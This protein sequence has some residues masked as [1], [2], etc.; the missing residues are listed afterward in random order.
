MSLDSDID[1]KSSTPSLYSQSWSVPKVFEEEAGNDRSTS[2]TNGDCDFSCAPDLINERYLYFYCSHGKIPSKTFVSLDLETYKARFIELDVDLEWSKYS[3]SLV[4]YKNNLV[5]FGKRKTD[6]EERNHQNDFLLNIVGG[7][8]QNCDI[9]KIDDFSFSS[10]HGYS[11]DTLDTNIFLFGGIVNEEYS[12]DILVM[13]L[14]G[15]PISPKSY[16]TDKENA[17]RWS[18]LPL[19]SSSPPGRCNHATTMIGNKLIVHG[20]K[21]KTGLL[22]DLWLLDLDTMSWTEIRPVGGFPCPREGHKFVPLGNKFYMYG[23]FDENQVIRN[24]LWCFNLDKQCWLRTKGPSIAEGNARFLTMNSCNDR[25]F[26]TFF[27]KML[28]S[29]HFHCYECDPTRLSWNNMDAYGLPVFNHV[30][31]NSSNTFNYTIPLGKINTS[32][33]KNRS[34]ASFNFYDYMEPSHKTVK[35]LGHRHYGS[36][37]EQGLEYLKGKK[38]NSLHHRRNSDNLSLREFGQSSPFAYDVDKTITSLPIAYDEEEDNMDNQ[39]FLSVPDYVSNRS[40]DLQTFNFSSTDDRI[41]WLEEQLLFCMT[42]G[43][44]LKP[45]GHLREKYSKGIHIHSQPLKMLESLHVMEEELSKTEFEFNR[46]ACNMISEN[47]QLLAEKDAAQSSVEFHIKLLQESNINSLTRMLSERVHTL[48]IDVQHSLA[49]ATFY[50]QGY[51]EL[52]QKV[53]ELQCMNSIMRNHQAELN[54]NYEKL[55]SVFE[56][57]DIRVGLLQTENNLLKLDVSRLSQDS[58]DCQSKCQTL[59]YDNYELETKLIE[60]CDRMEMQTNVVEASASALDVSNTAILSFEDSLR[61]EKEENKLLQEN[62]LSLTYKNSRLNAEVER[63]QLENKE[64]QKVTDQVRSDGTYLKSIIQNGLSKLLSSDGETKKILQDSPRASQKITHL[65]SR[66][67]DI[68]Q[69]FGKQQSNFENTI[70]ELVF[71]QRKCTEMKHAYSSAVAEKGHLLSQMG[72][73][74]DASKAKESESQRALSGSKLSQINNHPASSKVNSFDR[75]LHQRHSSSNENP[76]EK[77]NA[78]SV[79]DEANVDDSMFKKYQRSYNNLISAE[80]LT[81]S[82]QQK[83]LHRLNLGLEDQKKQLIDTPNAFS[84]GFNQT[85]VNGNQGRNVNQL[86]STTGDY[87]ANRIKQLEDD[88]QQALTFA[89]CSDESFQQLNYNFI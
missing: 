42:Q 35:S 44:A 4:C 33:T 58:L 27:R 73:F 9:M 37:D 48:E 56:E 54:E 2:F 64:N 24:E 45:P 43:Y 67:V 11:L 5:L 19:Q 62:C 59:E 7:N 16:F 88:Y 28:N 70:Q 1:A 65:E 23:G 60:L 79:N 30:R 38:R 40:T 87:Y 57:D 86:Q 81:M 66:L 75:L 80:P 26:L 39:S 31:M 49:E 82:R 71:S 72:D 20:G 51:N 46:N 69:S 53:E 83:T 15:L 61:R 55:H 50:Y 10:R 68:Q 41:A 78:L 22:G 84:N 17:L 6:D 32:H 14:Q 18:E 25:L 34:N 29:Y 63:L 52:K 89:N 3:P 74:T 77:I 8:F 21:N 85:V 47:A 12:N 36:L 13:N 76:E